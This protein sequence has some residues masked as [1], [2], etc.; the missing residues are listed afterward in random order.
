MTKSSHG[1]EI[2]TDA[3]IRAVNSLDS[4]NATETKRSASSGAGWSI[5]SIISACG[6]IAAKWFHDELALV[7]AKTAA[8]GSH[9]PDFMIHKI[10][11]FMMW[12]ATILTIVAVLAAVFAC[13]IDKSTIRR[14]IVVVLSAASLLYWFILV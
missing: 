4:V 2:L 1:S 14:T 3:Q 9:G 11:S 12:T 13:R 10:A 8:K 7:L 5:L 6:G